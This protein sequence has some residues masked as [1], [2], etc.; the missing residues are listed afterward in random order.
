MVFLSGLLPQEETVY[1][2]NELTVLYSKKENIFL[3]DEYR[4]PPS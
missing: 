3:T 2:S 4:V 1:E